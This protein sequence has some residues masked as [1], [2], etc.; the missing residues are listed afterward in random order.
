M[1]TFIRKNI[2][3]FFLVIALCDSLIIGLKLM[4]LHLI[5]KPLLVPTLIIAVLLNTTRSFDR[6][7]I[8][9]GLFFSFMGDIFLLID[10]RYP[11]L[12]IAGLICFLLTH[13]LYCWYFLQLK[14]TSVSLLKMHPYLALLPIAYTVGLL[15]I[16]YPTLGDLKIPVVIYAG[17][18]GCMLLCSLY[19]YKNILPAA[20]I[21]FTTGALCFV[22]SDSLF[23]INKFYYSFKHAGFLIIFTYCAA[24]FLIVKGFIKNHNSS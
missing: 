5:L 9:T 18:L 23:A 8:V 20:A 16:L 21:L 11:V 19:A 7:L 3:I 6:R 17:V 4:S 10:D 24:Q 22:L 13:L 15:A 2:L 14:R 1:Q 12:F